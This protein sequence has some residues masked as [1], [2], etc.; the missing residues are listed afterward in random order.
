MKKREIR[1]TNSEKLA[2]LLPAWDALKSEHGLSSDA[3]VIEF[4]LKGYQA[5]QTPAHSPTWDKIDSLIQAQMLLNAGD[6]PLSKR[7]ISTAWVQKETG[8]FFGAIQKYFEQR[9][10]EIAAHNE[11]YGLDI[12]YNRRI[13]NER[14]RL[15]KTQD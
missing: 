13:L 4:L 6:D 9:Q 7:Y 2:V 3:D 1:V 8:C 10:S 12:G 15:S 5:H 14:K 11:K